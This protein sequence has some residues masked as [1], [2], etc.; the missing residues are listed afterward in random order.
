[1]GSIP[2]LGHLSSSFFFPS[3]FLFVSPFSLLFCFF[4]YFLF[5]L[6]SLH[7]FNAQALIFFLV[8][9]QTTPKRFIHALTHAN[10]TVVHSKERK[11]GRH[12]CFNIH[13]IS[14]LQCYVVRTVFEKVAPVEAQ[15]SSIEERCNATVQ[16]AR[17]TRK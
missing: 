14:R 10:S 6:C 13:V 1:M 8:L 16:Q 17:A 15:A 3:H 9:P 4:S 7:H 11:R 2:A 12:R 5:P